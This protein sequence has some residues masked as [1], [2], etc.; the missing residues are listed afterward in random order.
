MAIGLRGDDLGHLYDLHG[1]LADLDE[2]LIR[3]LHERSFL[4]DP[5]R[6][7]RAVRFE[8]RLGFR[9]T[10]ETERVARVAV[11]EGALATV[12]GKRIRDELMD[13]L[14]EVEVPDAVERCPTS[15]STA[16]CIPRSGRTPSSWRPRLSARWP[17]EP[18]GRWPPW[19]PC[20]PPP[21]RSSRAGWTGFSW[22]HATATR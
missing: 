10:D 13:L 3:V 21:P 9:M 7:L 4:D 2:R 6:L 22:T 16:A 18:N 5:T 15:G 17:S 1:G 14:G 8:T 11:L 19:R 20:A 12:S